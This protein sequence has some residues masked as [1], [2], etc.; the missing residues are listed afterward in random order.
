M[1]YQARRE[2]QDVEATLVCPRLDGGYPLLPQQVVIRFE[3]RNRGYSRLSTF[4]FS[5]QKITVGPTRPEGVPLL[6][7]TGRRVWA[8]AFG[9]TQ[10]AE[11][12]KNLLINLQQALAHR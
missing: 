6:L 8:I 11:N 2:G 10:E 5:P 1:G 9:S 12:W 7:D 4:T 3:G